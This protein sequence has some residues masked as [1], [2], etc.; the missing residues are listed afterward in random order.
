LSNRRSSTKVPF[1][2]IYLICT[3]EDSKQKRKIA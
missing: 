3:I 2:N 1:P